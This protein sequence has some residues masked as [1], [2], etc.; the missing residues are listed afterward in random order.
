MALLRNE[1]GRADGEIFNIGNPGNNAS[2]RELAEIIVDVMKE[3]PEYAARVGNA[4]FTC[5]PAEEYYRNGYDDMKNRVPSIEKI[6]NALGWT[7]KI[8]LR[9]AVRMTLIARETASSRP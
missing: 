5:V 1:G 7:P 2:I 8:G 6:K 9:D 4:R 3:I